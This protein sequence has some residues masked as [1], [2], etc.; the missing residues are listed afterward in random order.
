MNRTSKQAAFALGAVE[1][2]LSFVDDAV[3]F[4]HSADIV[5]KLLADFTAVCQIIAAFRISQHGLLGA[6]FPLG[7]VGDHAVCCV[8]S[9]GEEANVGIDAFHKPLRF[10]SHIG[11]GMH[12][13]QATGAVILDFLFPK[14]D[15]GLGA[16][17]DNYDVLQLFQMRDQVGNG[18]G[19]I[20][21]D[22]ITIVNQGSGLFSNDALGGIVLVFPEH[23]RD[24]G[25]GGLAQNHTAVGSMYFSLLFQDGQ[26]S[27][28]GGM[29]HI[30]HLRQGVYTD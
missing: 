26:I 16:V 4:V 8:T 28:D 6:D 21:K 5:G 17:G 11:H 22:H 9:A 18:G 3:D 14:G 25:V 27:T 19:G 23:Q 13:K 24:L 29:A 20:Q 7:G 12:Q 15:G 2:V 30:K 10:R 1:G